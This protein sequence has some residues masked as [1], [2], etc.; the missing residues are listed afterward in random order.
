MKNN[1]IKKEYTW[2]QALRFLHSHTNYKIQL[3]DCSDFYSWYDASDW[4]LYNAEFDAF[5]IFNFKASKHWFMELNLEYFSKE[6]GLFI[7]EP[8]DKVEKEF[9]EDSVKELLERN[10]TPANDK[11]TKTIYLRDVKPGQ[12]FYFASDMSRDTCVSYGKL[13]S[14]RYSV[15][16][17][18]KSPDSNYGEFPGESE[19]CLVNGE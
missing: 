8:I 5:F 3:D 19:V 17:M 18:Y 7:V 6:K 4:Y 11:K 15:V 10:S 14:G 16:D 1:I 13:P 9:I 12:E 2:E